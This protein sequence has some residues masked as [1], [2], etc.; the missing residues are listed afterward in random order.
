MD[1]LHALTRN[2]KFWQG[3]CETSTDKPEDVLLLDNKQLLVLVKYIV[4]EGV[5]ICNQKDRKIAI[6]KLEA[7]LELFLCCSV[8]EDSTRAVVMYLADE[9]M[10]LDD[11]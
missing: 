2:P 9:M 6:Q 11:R 1:F 5:G 3:H 10:S 4:V 7:R 8:R